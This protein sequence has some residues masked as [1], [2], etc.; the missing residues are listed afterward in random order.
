MKRTLIYW[1]LQISGWSLYTAFLVFSILAFADE[2][3]LRQILPLQILIGLSLMFA[4]HFERMLLKRIDVFQYSMIRM[5][6]I[7]IGLSF[8]MAF[9][10]QIVIHGIIYGLWDWGSIRPFNINES[11]IYWL[12]SSLLLIIWTFIYISIKS[13]EFRKTKEVENWKLKAEL[14]EAELGMLKAQI[15]P[16]FLFNALN[17]IRSLIAEDSNRAR[18]MVTSLS[19]LLRYAIQHTNNDVVTL[20]EEL[21]ILK[22]YFDLE[23]MHFEDRLSVSIEC[24]SELFNATIP[25]MSIQM[26]AENA[27]KHGISQRAEGGF[28]TIDI[29]AD[30]DKIKVTIINSGMIQQSDDEGI[31]LSNIRQRLEHRFGIIIPISL[32]QTS[33]DQVT[34]QFII[35]LWT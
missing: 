1:L 5:I 16:H 19:G 14:K 6:F 17:N 27:I 10:A 28:I 31:G 2:T 8:L 18:E 11:M 15:N 30:G 23:K 22:I 26:L 25:P 33:P 20:G 34:T 13:F 9:A 29:Q 3:L 24:D 32:E 7:S 35:P 12:N 4:S 21:D